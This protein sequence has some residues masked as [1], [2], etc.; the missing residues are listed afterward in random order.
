MFEVRKERILESF[1]LL[2][3]YSSSSIPTWRIFMVDGLHSPA[4]S[5]VE[6]PKDGTV[7]WIRRI[8]T[9]ENQSRPWEAADVI[10][11]Y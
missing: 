8:W 4:E 3:S 1:R 10:K 11:D 9:S 5:F 2:S 6:R 7:S